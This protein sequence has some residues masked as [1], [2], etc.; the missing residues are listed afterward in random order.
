M[1]GAVLGIG[2]AAAGQAAGALVGGIIDQKIL[3]SGSEAVSRGRSSSLRLQTANEGA[4]IPRIYGRMRVAGQVIWS[5]RFKE[6]VAAHGGG[7]GGGPKVRDYSYTISFAI[8]LCEGPITRIGRVWADGK[9]IDLDG[10]SWRLHRGT[11]GQGPD[12]VIEATEGSAP[13]FRGVAYLVFEDM[14][15]EPY[16][17]RI[18]Q[19]SVEVFRR[20][21][22][23]EEAGDP[24]APPVHEVVRAVALS[25]GT[26]EF[27][28]ETEP[29]RLIAGEGEERYANLHAS[30]ARTDAVV[31]LDQ[32]MDDLPNVEAVSLIVSWFGDDL[33]CG[34]CLIRPGVEHLEMR[35]EPHVW[36]VGGIDRGGAYLVS[37]DE[38]GRPVFGG[39]PTDASVIRFIRELKARGIRVNFYPFILMD[40]PQGNGKPDPWGGEEQAPF[41]WRGRISTDLAPDRNG[42]TDITSGAAAEVAHFF[43]TAAANDFEPADETVRFLGEEEWGLRRFVLHYA[44][45]CRLAGGVDA[46]CI[47]SELRSLTQI[48]SSRTAYPAVAELVALAR[49]VRAVVGSGTKIGY[50]ADWSEYFGH[51]PPD[52]SGDRLFHLDPLWA[53]PEIDFVGIDWY[54]PLTDWRDEDGHLD[55]QEAATIYDAKYLSSRFAAGE[56]FDWYYAS[57]EDRRRQHRTP[58]QDGQFGEHWIWRF[59]DLQGWWSNPHHER[60]DGVRAS[61]S[62]SWIPR[63]KPIW[64]TEIGCGAVDKATNQPN[65]FVDPKSSEGG[66]PWYSH[67][68]RDD[69]IQRRMLQATHDF[70]S[71][72]RNNPLSPRYGERMLDLS[73]AYVWTWDVRPWPEFPRRLDAWSDG[74]NHELGHWLNGRLAAN[75]LEE[76]VSDICTSAGVRDSDASALHGLVEGY[77]QDRVQTPREAMQSLMLAYGF[78][79]FESGGKMKFAMRAGSK[80]HRISPME[81]VAFAEGAWRTIERTRG[82]DGAAPRQ[83]RIAY[84][85]SDGDY[86]AGVAEAFS[87]KPQAKGVEG[88][89]L[90]IAFS[91]SQAVGVAERWMRESEFS[92]N[93]ISF[94]LSRSRSGLEPGDLV[95]FDGDCARYRVDRIADGD[96][97]ELSGT[98]VEPAV[99]G[100]RLPQLPNEPSSP[101]DGIE[102]PARPAYRLLDVPWSAF[103]GRDGQAYL[104]AW[105]KPWRGAVSVYGSDRD[106]GYEP[107][108]S[109]RKPPSVALLE[110]PLLAATPWRWTRDTTVRVKMVSGALSTVDALAVLNG[111]NLAALSAG[112]GKWEI[113]QFQN[114]RLIGPDEYE[115]SRFLRGQAGTEQLIGNPAPEGAMLILLDQRLAKI[116]IGDHALGLERHYRI[117]PSGISDLNSVSFSH[118]TWAYGGASLVPHAPTHVQAERLANGDISISWLRR[119]RTDFDI[120][121]GDEVPL[122]EKTESYNV[123]V[124]GFGGDLIRKFHTTASSAIYRYAQQVLDGA[125][126]ALRFEIMQLSNSVG[127]GWKV[128]VILNA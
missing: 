53:D 116:E 82:Q 59:K 85:R 106:F 98:L 72:S 5:T 36:E 76:I 48:R 6:H 62:T 15:L 16:G 108:A 7:K 26:G 77:V 126:A 92:R 128:E 38:N 120:W 21:V 39:T 74:V 113:L 110:E 32:L 127:E 57:D 65:I 118:A 96:A 103:G 35:T 22:R 100:L 83:V 9:R 34:R 81:V 89:E 115:L 29:V 73:N 95:R 10:L 107:L 102:A 124:R 105:S 71:D 4:P 69:L 67:G 112:E 58:I 45:L 90:P 64:F 13:A 47:G 12:P 121:G 122:E 55:G 42:T 79:A 99:Y 125:P 51:Q 91:R 44:H 8:A 52:G 43:G 97:R 50:A 93:R 18:P 78:D 117:G 109:V 1:G 14:P 20:P 19:L 11:E 94:S 60:V 88:S 63:S 66:L 23:R 37:S 104:A 87:P 68:G 41:P 31:A 75:E 80:E 86:D 3:G 111:A 27:S 24:A 70:W 33:R 101:L 40:L 119:S 56:G 61:A 123:Y 49:E 17:N 25:P 2:V 28:L 84:T 30:S 54:A 46:F 114:A